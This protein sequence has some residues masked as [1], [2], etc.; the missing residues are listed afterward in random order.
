M[1]AAP[2]HDVPT[3]MSRRDLRLLQSVADGRVECTGSI[4]PDFFVDGVA[5]C[6]HMAARAL[7]R[8][9]M[10][11]PIRRRGLRLPVQLTAAGRDALAAG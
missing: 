11:R 2:V 5:C 3:G 6:D 7:V 1:R 9:G 10:I 4:E 8:G